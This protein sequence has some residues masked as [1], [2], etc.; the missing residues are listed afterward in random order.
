MSELSRND[1]LRVAS[2]ARLQ[3]S[4]EEVTAAQHDLG[5][6]IR[7]IDQL[8]SLNTQNISATNGLQPRS[9]V[10]RADQAA[11]TLEPGQAVLNAPAAEGN[12]FRIPRILE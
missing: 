1:V 4:E 9:N 12:Y 7:Y 10:M 2:L 11:A 5:K 8:S 6:V 3:L